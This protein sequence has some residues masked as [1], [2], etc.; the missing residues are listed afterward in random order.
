MESSRFENIF[1]ATP[2]AID[3]IKNLDVI[4][5]N[6]YYC[7]S[8]CLYCYWLKFKWI[9][10]YHSLFKNV[11]FLPK[12]SMTIAF[13]TV[14][15]IRM[16]K[17]NFTNKRMNKS[18]TQYLH[19]NGLQIWKPKILLRPSVY[20]LRPF[21]RSSI[22][23]LKKSIKY[24]NVC[25]DTLFK[26]IKPNAT[27]SSIAVRP[28]FSE[29]FA[30]FTVVG[31]DLT[32]LWAAKLLY[33]YDSSGRYFL[34]E[35]FY[36]RSFEH[37]L[38]YFFERCYYWITFCWNLGSVRGKSVQTV[39]SSQYIRLGYVI[40]CTS[41]ICRKFGFVITV[42]SELYTR[43]LI[44]ISAFD[45]GNWQRTRQRQKLKKYAFEFQTF[46]CVCILMSMGLIHNGQIRCTY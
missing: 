38:L 19:S 39:L 23:I 13:I 10:C 26:S 36:W 16:N 31:S 44:R 3:R 2:E 40:L 35:H 22:K 46:G 41:Q 25:A 1:N 4:I 12:S 9:A 24:L 32:K 14:H 43:V 11:C 15:A 8:V 18:K 27:R 7:C 28:Y 6:Y 45:L 5:I 21:G 33:I 29:L 30:D 17:W 42:N 37:A 20:L 34:F